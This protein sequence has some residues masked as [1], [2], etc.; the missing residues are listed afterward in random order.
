MTLRSL[1]LACALTLVACTGQP[2]APPVTTAPTPEAPEVKP[3]ADQDPGSL[4]ASADK[5]FTLVPS[6]VETQGAL[7][8]AGIET[9]MSA[10]IEKRDFNFD[11]ADQDDTAIRTGVLLANTLLTVKTSSDEELLARIGHIQA[12]MIVLKGGKDIDL[13]IQDMADRVKAGAVNRDELLKELDELSGAVVPELEFN[14]VQR[15][16]PLIQAGAWLQG[17][18]L[19]AKACKQGG[20]PNAADTILKQPQVVDYFASYVR[21]EGADKAPAAVTEK[22]EASLASLKAVAGKTEP[23]TDADVDTVIQ[24]TEDVLA[25]L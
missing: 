2:T 21:E 22:L 13:T 8:G 24:V 9:K 11:T 19:V 23:L 10:L 14:G 20:K 4:A 16:V 6:P 18:N 15:I 7:E 17:A 1:S 3:L 25:L 12:G 5:K